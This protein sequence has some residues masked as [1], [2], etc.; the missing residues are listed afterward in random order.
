METATFG[1]RLKAL[2]K[3]KNFTQKE[4]E[5]RFTCV[6]AVQQQAEG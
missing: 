3:Q 1:E 2:R 5:T 6:D 4:S